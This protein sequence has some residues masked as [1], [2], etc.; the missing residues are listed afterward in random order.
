MKKIETVWSRELMPGRFSGY[1]RFKTNLSF[2]CFLTFFS[3]VFNLFTKSSENFQ[4]YGESLQSL[5][6]VSKSI[7]GLK[8]T[9]F[10]QKRRYLSGQILAKFVPDFALFGDLA[11]FDLSLFKRHLYQISL[12]T[13]KKYFF[14]FL[15]QVAVNFRSEQKRNNFHTKRRFAR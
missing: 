13:R 15:G 8:A 9:F 12:N 7:F 4:E 3:L 10:G 1:S 6:L 2:L 11:L 5:V 14:S